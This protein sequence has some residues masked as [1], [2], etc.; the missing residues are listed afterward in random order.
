M[1]KWPGFSYKA[2]LRDIL[3]LSSIVMAVLLW[4]VVSKIVNPLLLPGPL[5]VFRGGYELYRHI[6]GVSI[7]S[8]LIRVALGFAIGTSLGM[9]LAFAMAW[10][11]YIEWAVDP[12]IEI[13]RPI[14]AV[15]LIPLFILWLGLGEVPRVLVVVFASFVVVVVTTRE[16]IK[17][18]PSR[19][20]NA[21]QCLGAQSKSILFRTIILPAITPEIFAGIKM[22][23]AAS[24]DL[25]AAAEFIGAQRGLGYIIINAKRFLYTNGVIFGILLF[26]IFAWLADKLIRFLDGKANSWAERAQQT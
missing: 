2:R 14:P 13:L 12:L 24:F 20:I 3:G 21:A 8:T 15:A 10:N 9:L 18:V 11:R 6:L 26:A 16:A 19:Y 1:G 7:Y 5:E 25:S 23:A 17:N 4:Y 22:A